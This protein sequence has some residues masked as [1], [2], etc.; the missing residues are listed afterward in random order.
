MLSPDAR[1]PL[2]EPMIS[3][4]LILPVP[5]ADAAPAGPV[6]TARQ[7]WSTWA[8]GVWLTGISLGFLQ[9]LAG[10]LVV[11]RAIRRGRPVVDA[12]WLTLLA[13]ASA[14]LAVR[15]KVALRQ[16]DA[17]AVPVVW[18]WRRPVVL[19]PANADS[20][21]SEQRRAFLLHELAHVV[22]QDGL[23]QALAAVAHAV[24]WPHPLVWWAVR[25]LRAEAERACDDR[26]LLAG[27]EAPEYAQYQH[28]AARVKRAARRLPS[29]TSAVVERTHLG[30][31][32]I[33]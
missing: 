4:S 3:E 10:N 25:R 17:V 16:T 28:E 18:G 33:T 13:E 9:F 31:L 6:P 23:A 32:L 29:N 27:T 11:Y 30:D 1:Q 8:A 20:W 24:Y 22:R 21:P 2:P 26:E 14:R 7:G 12:E 19:L 5:V 15:R